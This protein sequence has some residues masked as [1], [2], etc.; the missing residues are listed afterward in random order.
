MLGLAVVVCATAVWLATGASRGWT[1]TSVPVRTLDE[2]TGLEAIH[3]QP[4]FVPGLDFL[5]TAALAG[6]ALAGCS[7]FFNHR[8]HPP[9]EAQS[10]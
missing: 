7:F 1:K 9:T 2:V 10:S 5:G 8:K 6:A 4:R 3:Y